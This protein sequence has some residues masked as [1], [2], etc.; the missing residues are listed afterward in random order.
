MADRGSKADRAARAKMRV[1]YVE[2]EPLIAMET[3]DALLDLGF[4]HVSMC[5]TFD[6]ANSIVQTARFDL[7]ILDMNLNG[8]LSAPLVK[9]LREAGTAV[10]VAT[11]YD[12]EDIAGDDASI[13]FVRKPFGLQMLDEAI[14]TAIASA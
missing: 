1:L 4:R 12:L 10:V 8:T 7:A 13:A 11:G 14:H 9:N 6:Q 5:H 2:D 3:E